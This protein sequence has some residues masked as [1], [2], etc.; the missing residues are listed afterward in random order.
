MLEL[1][2]LL[3]TKPATAAEAVLNGPDLTLQTRGAAL[4]AGRSALG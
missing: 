1:Q 3:F 4:V 2:A